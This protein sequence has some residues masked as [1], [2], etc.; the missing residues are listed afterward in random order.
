MTTQDELWIL[1]RRQDII[2][3]ASHFIVVL[4]DVEPPFMS[5]T[6]RNVSDRVGYIHSSKLTVF[7]SLFSSFT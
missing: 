4:Y 1:N 5:K 2:V 7:G 6:N 3:M